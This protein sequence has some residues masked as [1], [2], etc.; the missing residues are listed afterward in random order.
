MIPHLTWL[1]LVSRFEIFPI[2]F[3]L[4]LL[5][6]FLTLIL[7]TTMPLCRPL[8]QL[9]NR[10]YLFPNESSFLILLYDKQKILTDVCKHLYTMFLF[11][12]QY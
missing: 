10:L 9:L 12:S 2:A 3:P 5:I 4:H 1:P 7:R 11:Y 8:R 6:Y